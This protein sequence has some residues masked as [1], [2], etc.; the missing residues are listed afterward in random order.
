MEKILILITI[1]ILLSGGINSIQKII[2]DDYLYQ[3][4]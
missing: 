4:T 3:N 2:I 1:M